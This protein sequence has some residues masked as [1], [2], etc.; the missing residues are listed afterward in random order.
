MFL[1][2]FI[3]KFNYLLIEK[4]IIRFKYI[5]FGVFFYAEHEN[6]CFKLVW[7][8]FIHHL[9]KIIKNFFYL[10]LIYYKIKIKNIFRYNPGVIFRVEYE[11]WGFKPL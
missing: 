10:I 1:I 4:C 3:Y 11:K 6:R 7:Q 9:V 8:L 5:F 2:L